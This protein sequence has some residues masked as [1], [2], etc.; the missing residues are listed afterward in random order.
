MA[1]ALGIA[2]IL[3]P[4]TLKDD[5]VVAQIAALNPDMG[6]VAAYGEILRKNVLAIPRLWLPQHPPIVITVAPRTSPSHQCHPRRRPR[7]L[8]SW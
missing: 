6:V 7:G 3:Q 4:E 8:A 1:Q 5:A 2:Q